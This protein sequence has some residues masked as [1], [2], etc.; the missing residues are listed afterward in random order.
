MLLLPN[1]L[2]L[3][4]AVGFLSHMAASFHGGLALS[5]SSFCIATATTNITTVPA[6]PPPTLSVLRPKMCLLLKKL[7][8]LQIR[9]LQTANY[10]AS[11]TLQERTRDGLQAKESRPKA[12]ENRLTASGPLPARGE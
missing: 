2:T 9:L 11:Q 8:A 12:T 5:C 4:N 3:E 10:T 1:L 7:Q 6:A